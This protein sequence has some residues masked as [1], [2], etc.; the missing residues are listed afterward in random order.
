MRS[1]SIIALL[2]SQL[3]FAQTVI[4]VNKNAGSAINS[5]FVVAGSPFVTAKFVNL[6]EGTPYFRDEW[7]TALLVNDKGQQYKD[8]KAKIDLISR[9]VHYLDEKSIEYIATTPIVQVVFTDDA[10]NN[11]K[12]VHSSTFPK[13]ASK[14]QEGWYLWLASGTASLYK[15]FSKTTSESTPYGSAT[16]EQH[17]RTTESY[18]VLYNNAFMEI[19][20]LKDAPTVL[21]NKKKE[22]EDFLKDKDNSKDGMDDRFAALIDHYNLLFKEQK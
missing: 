13:T 5:F 7:M 15:F 9:D 3:C 11:Y 1:L 17:I 8:V 14:I 21:A 4:D 2:L 18:L 20:K 19:K 16:V 10:G 12:F 6:T 22:L